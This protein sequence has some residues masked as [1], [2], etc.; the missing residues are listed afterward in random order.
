MVVTNKPVTKGGIIMILFDVLEIFDENKKINVWDCIEPDNL[1]TFYDGRNSI[2]L[3]Y[4][5]CDVTSLSTHFDEYDNETVLD[6]YIK[7]DTKSRCINDIADYLRNEFEHD[8][9]TINN[10]LQ[11]REIGLAYTTSSQDGCENVELQASYRLDTET[12]ILQGG[13]CKAV[14]TVKYEDINA[15][16]DFNYLTGL[17]DDLVQPF[18]EQ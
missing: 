4:N 17:C 1:L 9:I 15:Y 13:H 10:E 8:E 14:Q 2:D 3:I 16:L 11:D 7:Q 6:V 5:Y 18:L 12:L